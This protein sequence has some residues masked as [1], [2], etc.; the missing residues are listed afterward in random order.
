VSPAEPASPATLALLRP[1]AFAGR[2]V[3]A[4]LLG[5]CAAALSAAAAEPPAGA[6]AA[7]QAPT[8]QR[9]L[10]A[11]TPQGVSRAVWTH[12]GGRLVLAHGADRALLVHRADGTLERRVARPGRGDLEFAV[13]YDLARTVDGFVL[14]DFPCHYLWLDRDLEPIRSLRTCSSGRDRGDVFPFR[15]LVLVDGGWVA[16]ANAVDADGGGRFG[17]IRQRFAAHPAP[18]EVLAELFPPRSDPQQ[19]GDDDA[20]QLDLL[21]LGMLYLAQAGERTYWLRAAEGAFRIDRLDGDRLVP[22]AAFPERF[23]RVPLLPR[24]RQGIGDEALL[25]SVVETSTFAAGLYGEGRWL[26][27]LGREAVPGGDT[28]WTLTAIDPVAD[29]VV[30]TA[31]LPTGVPALAVAPGPVEWA[32]VELGGVGEGQVVGQRP[33]RSLLRVATAALRPGGAL[34]ISAGEEA[35]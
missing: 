27:V 24:R 29:R 3:A 8:W 28:R 15:P 2:R 7:P 12:D 11:P 35:R 5:A 30:G 33:P 34:L 31:T 4:T 18:F 23:A 26:Y 9:V 32:F 13:P 16:V 10:L 25:Q 20:R 6:P 21:S 17:L 14:L 19:I 22:L 1:S